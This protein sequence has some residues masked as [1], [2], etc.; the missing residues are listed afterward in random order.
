MKELSDQR[1]YF[2]SSIGNLEGRITSTRSY[3]ATQNQLAEAQRQR[4]LDI[5]RANRPPQE[6]KVSPKKKRYGGNSNY[7]NQSFKSGK[8]LKSTLKNR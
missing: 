4:M 2:N 1:E 3:M 6:E 8:S 7:D 5:E